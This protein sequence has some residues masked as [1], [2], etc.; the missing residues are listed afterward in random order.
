ML[1]STPSS[2][3]T[4]AADAVTNN[5]LADEL[6]QAA[7][8]LTV[9]QG[10]L[11]LALLSSYTAEEYRSVIQR[12][13]EQSRRILDGFD[14]VRRLIHVSNADNQSLPSTHETERIE[15]LHV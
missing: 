9:L 14:Q 2:G 4:N 8:P 13:M 12:A 1:F 7:Q 11:E 15:A 5:A 6:H 3:M 10:L